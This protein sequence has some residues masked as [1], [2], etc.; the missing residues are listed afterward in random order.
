MPF[1]MGAARRCG[2]GAVWIL[3]PLFICYSGRYRPVCVGAG[4]GDGVG[5][6]KLESL[7]AC[8]LWM[9]F[10]GC[11]WRKDKWSNDNWCDKKWRQDVA[12]RD[13]ISTRRWP[14]LQQKCSNLTN[15]RTIH[16]GEDNYMMS[17]KI[18]ARFIRLICRHFLQYIHDYGIAL[19]HG[20]WKCI[21]AI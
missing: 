14:A 20:E 12:K 4:A 2:F 18:L 15:Q 11:F 5:R 17:L 16:I 3:L 10:F 8:W 19:I 9:M 7:V 6:F 1:F 21:C 13:D